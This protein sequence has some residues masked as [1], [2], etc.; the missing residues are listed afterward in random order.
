MSEPEAIVAAEPAADFAAF[1]AAE[2]AKVVG[3]TAPE[4]I[5]EAVA[6][7]EPAA[8]AVAADPTPVKLS[9]RQQHINELERSRAQAEERA[10]KLEARLAEIEAGPKTAEKPAA[11][12]ASIDPKDPEPQ[13]ADFD[14]YRAFVKALSRWEIREDK[15]EAE[16]ASAAQAA[17]DREASAATEFE[18]RVSTWVDRRDSYIDKNP[19]SAERLTAFLDTMRARTPMGDAI[20]DSEVGAELADYL[21]SHPEEAERIARLAPIPALLA[22]GKLEA[23]IPTHASAR[24]QPAA[25]TVTT[26]PAPPTTLAARSADPSD[27]VAAA[28]ARGDYSA[29][30]FEENRKALAAR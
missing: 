6:E 14:D 10:A 12:A 22:L 16:A 5:A 8:G 15:R 28:V 21:A 25:K 19:A 24:A 3:D 11:A 2:N 7:P 29:F 17:R 1:E 9:K 13:E 4:P 23:S 27:P 30:E 26:A 18:T 20:M